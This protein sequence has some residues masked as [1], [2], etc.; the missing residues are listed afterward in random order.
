ME[1]KPR[2]ITMHSLN[3]G[4]ITGAAM[5]VCSLILYI[6]NLYMNRPLGFLQYLILIGGMVYGTLEYRKNYRNGFLTYGQ[7]FTTCFMIGLFATILL[8]IYSFIFTTYI[9]PGFVQ[10]ILDKARENMVNSGSE[11]T[12]QQIESALEITKRFTT[13]LLMTVLGLVTGLFFSSILALVAAIFLKKED[14]TLT[15]TF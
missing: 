14:Q 8:V 3:Y 5:V 15:N 7:A 13:P 6:L 4:L 12:E 2:S 1:E 9:Y 10:E 11:M